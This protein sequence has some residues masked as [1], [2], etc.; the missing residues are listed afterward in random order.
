MITDH[1]PLLSL[2]GKNKQ[3]PQ[4]AASR[5]KRWGII[6]SAYNYRLEFVKSNDNCA[7]ALSRLP[8]NEKSDS[9]DLE[10]D[11]VLSINQ[12]PFPITSKDI[13]RKT[14]SNKILSVVYD[15]ILKGLEFPKGPEFDKFRKVKDQLNI[16]QSCILYGNRVV[17]PPDY[18]KD[19]LNSLHESHLGIT[20]TKALE[21]YYVWYPGIDKD[22]EELINNCFQCQQLRN[23]TPKHDS[24]SWEYP[25]KPWDRIHIDFLGPFNGMMYFVVVDAYSK[26]PEV[27]KMNSTTT[28]DTIARLNQ[29]S[30]RY[31]LPNKL[32][33]DNGPQFISYE[34]GEA[35]RLRSGCFDS[36]SFSRE[37]PF[38][39]N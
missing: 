37:S 1:K 22:I 33:S 18:E 16:D 27:F 31:G 14:K 6:L 30:A 24:H 4:L 36:I 34:F 5:L 8:I 28:S 11:S 20:R 17:I 29:L 38:L 13:A 10:S 35:L 21:R 26:W 19:V 39:I 3:L 15:C 23:E 12:I 25:N 7:D 2:F 9:M 32:A